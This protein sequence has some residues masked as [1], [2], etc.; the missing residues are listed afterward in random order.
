MSPVEL[1]EQSPHMPF[2]GVTWTFDDLRRASPLTMAVHNDARFK[3]FETGTFQGSRYIIA[4]S[5]NL[6]ST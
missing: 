5:R 6:D 3:A 1:K 2:G 4:V